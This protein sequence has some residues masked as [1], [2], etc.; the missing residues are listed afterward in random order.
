MYVPMIGTH[1]MTYESYKKYKEAAIK[2][3]KS[4]IVCP[5]SVFML[6]SEKDTL[7][8]PFYMTLDTRS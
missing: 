5:G 1:R 2:H 3:V 8:R 6:S 4:R 7:G